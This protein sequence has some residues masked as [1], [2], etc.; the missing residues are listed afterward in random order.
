M[1]TASE[2]CREA[3]ADAAREALADVGYTP[4]DVFR[5][6]YW[7]RQGKPEGYWWDDMGRKPRWRDG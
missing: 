4:L 7:L 2:A 6:R 3:P 1:C 5:A